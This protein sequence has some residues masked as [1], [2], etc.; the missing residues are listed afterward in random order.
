MRSI[1]GGILVQDRDS[2][3]WKEE[4]L[5]VVTKRTPNEQELR[6]LRF[7]FHVCKHVK[8]NAI[9]IARDATAIGIGGGQVSR[10]DAVEQAVHK[11]KKEKS[12]L[13]SDGFFPFADGVKVAADAGVGAIVQPG[14][15]KKDEEVIKTTNDLDLAMVFTGTRQFRH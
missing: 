7:A 11:A 15:S 5:Q 1:A 2:S 4:S 9:V 10:V 14:G 3:I 13:A 12:V 6:D 8:S